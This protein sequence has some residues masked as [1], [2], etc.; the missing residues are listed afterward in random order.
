MH[1][2]LV[3][4]LRCPRGHA[5]GWLVATADVVSDRRIVRGTLGCPTCGAEWPVVEGEVALDAAA[6]ADHVGAATPTAGLDAARLP[7]AGEEALRADALRAAALL[8]LRDSRG[9][10]ALLGESARLADAL[11]ELTGVLVLAVNAP[12]GVAFAHTR[13]RV[14]DAL[15][16]GVGTLRGAHVDAAHGAED[17]LASAVRA[18]EQG[19]RIVAPT[20]AMLPGD[21]RELAR[22]D[23]EW[24]AEVRVAASGLVPLRRGGDPMAR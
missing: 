3:E 22:D 13:L 7:T 9:A 24:V 20:S 19:G 15:P 17:W 2:D 12:A 4:S 5:D 8:D 23:A 18:V 11:V 21:L 6:P 1:V 10:V 14:S 16:L